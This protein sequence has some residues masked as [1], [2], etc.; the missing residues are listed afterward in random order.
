MAGKQGQRC[1][2][3]SKT[4]KC[5][6][7]CRKHAGGLTAVATP[8]ALAQSHSLT[9]EPT[10]VTF[11]M[12]MPV[13]FVCA[14]QAKIPAHVWLRSIRTSLNTIPRIG[15]PTPSAAPPWLTA[16]RAPAELVAAAHGGLH[17]PGG[18]SAGWLCAMP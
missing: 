18:I 4:S 6:H 17:L 14:L 7:F 1:D 11:R 10:A 13:Q 12:T 8:K 3:L 2:Q 16:E 15:I 9:L 5:S